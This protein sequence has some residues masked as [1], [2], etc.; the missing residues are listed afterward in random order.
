[1]P[2][3]V[4]LVQIGNSFS[5]QHYFPYSMGILQAYAMKH[6]ENPQDLKFLLPIYRRIP[7][8]DAV[9][10]LRGAEIVCF[11]VY[12]WNIRLS[13]A[14]AEALKRRNP[15]TIIAMGGPQVPRQD[16]PWEVEAFHRDHPFVDVAIHGMGKGE[17]SFLPLLE[18]I[19][20]RNWNAVPSASFVEGGKVRQ[21]LP[22]K[23]FV[24]DELTNLVPSP[25]QAGVFD[26]LMAANP[27]EQWIFPWETDRNCPFS[28]EF[29]GW[30][31]L[32]TKPVQWNLEHVFR[33]IDWIAR[34]KINSVFCCNANFGLLPRDI[35]IARYIAR[36]KSETGFPRLLNVQDTKNVRRRALEVRKILRDAFRFPAV[37]SLQSVD[38]VVLKNIRRDNI[39]L[40]DFFAI[41]R[42]F[43]ALGD[44]TMTDLILALPGETYDSW[45]NGISYVIEHGQHNRIQ[46][47]NLSI[48]PDAAMS[49]RD[50]IREFGL[51][52]V[53]TQVTN[54]HGK[55][56]I[57]EVPEMQ[58]LV[59]ATDAM[60]PEDWVRARA[61]AYWGGLYFDKMLQIP[62]IAAH[63][64][65][66]VT[67]RNVLE[68]FSSGVLNSGEFPILSWVRQ[69]FEGVARNIQSGGLEYCHAPQWLDIYWPA[70]EYVFV[71]LVAEDKLEAFFEEVA[72]AL[73]LHINIDP[74]ILRDATRLTHALLKLPLQTEDIEVEC[75]WNVWEF[76]RSVV[77]GAV[78]PPETAG[79]LAQEAVTG[80][81]TLRFYNA[82]AAF[83]RIVRGPNRYR[84]DRTLAVVDGV[85]VKRLSFDE[86]CER[87][88][89]YMNRSAAYIYEN[90]AN[91]TTGEPE[92][93]GYR[94]VFS[95]EYLA[96]LDP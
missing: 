84:I 74:V 43:A 33:D 20:S 60:P 27:D 46:F 45:A 77:S 87:V 56:E 93:K 39:S 64:L 29:C 95:G 32:E 7:V 34:H 91:L 55:V 67:Y 80:T 15:E 75:S 50:R 8:A 85:R 41:Q 44:K 71:K 57:E 4:G 73:A 13:L 19:S 30:G 5:G 82:G 42:E 63:E 79:L 11:S 89:W 47:N 18:S 94:G 59:I 65:G 61:F 21:T 38:P 31:D 83:P 54:V 76:Y 16:R 14:V 58:E 72:R 53:W 37:I 22:A 3:R 36:V 25:Y 88:V 6:L 12:T 10:E 62:V 2:I 1:M 70:D 17:R 24:G 86:W 68:V 23:G 78:I 48:V 69:F 52:T 40:D 90:V 28:C 26:E 51:K 35:E 81:S 9:A 96:L 66:G 92:P 49:H